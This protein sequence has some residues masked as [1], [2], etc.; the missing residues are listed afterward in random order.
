MTLDRRALGFGG[1]VDR[2]AVLRAHVVSLAHPLG[3]VVV[4]PEHLQQLVEADHGRIEHDLY[5]LGVT[6]ETTAR[7]LVCRVGCEATGVTN[8]RRID[9]IGLPELALGAPKAP[10]PK[11]GR[12][13][14]LWPRPH[15][16][17]AVDEVLLGHRHRLIGAPRQRVVGGDHLLLLL[18]DHDSRLRRIA[19]FE[20]R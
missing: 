1:V 16:G 3:R 8:G 6:G 11:H 7:L 12:L 10:E 13:E 2:A 14:T 4:L 20:Y 5:N 17:I 15:E 9:A 19:A 18:K